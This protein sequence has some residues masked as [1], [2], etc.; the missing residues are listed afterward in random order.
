[1]EKLKQLLLVEDDKVDAIT[2][3]RMWED[4]KAAL[5]MVHHMK[6]A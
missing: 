1:M 5:M 3:E 4:N 6:Q 2:I